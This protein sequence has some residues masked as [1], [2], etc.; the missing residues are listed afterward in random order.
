[1]H[2]DDAVLHAESI[3]FSCLL[4]SRSMALAV[5]HEPQIAYSVPRLRS[6]DGKVGHAIFF[7]DSLLVN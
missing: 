5:A 3:L 1:M 7:C 6:C 2:L 4:R